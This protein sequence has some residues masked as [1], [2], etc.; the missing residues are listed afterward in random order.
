MERGRRQ[1]DA[2]AVAALPQGRHRDPRRH[3]RQA[4]VPYPVRARPAGRRRQRPA[5]AA[6]GRKRAR[7]HHP[8]ARLHAGRAELPLCQPAA[9]RGGSAAVAAAQFL[10]AGDRRCRVHRR[11][12]DLPA[13]ARQ[14]R[15]QPLG[16]RP[17]PGHAR[18][19]AAGGRRAGR[20]RAQARPRAGARHARGADRRHAQPR[21]PR[22]GAGAARRGLPGRAHG[23]GRP[24]RHPPRP[25][26]HARR[27]GARAAGRLDRRLRSQ[28]HAG[29]VLARCRLGREARAAQSRARLPGRQ[30]RRRDAGAGRAAICAR[31]QHDRPLR[32][33]VGAGQQL[34]PGPRARAG[35]LL[36]A[37]RRRRAGDRQ[38]VLA[39][40]HA[41]RQRRPAAGPAR[42]QAHHRYRARADGASRL[43]PAQPQ[44]RALADLQLLLRQPG[45][46]PCRRRLG[47]PLLGRPGAGAGRHQPA[48]GGAPGAGDG[49]LAEVRTGA[50]RPHARRAGTRRR[51][52]HAVARRARDRR[53]GAGRLSGGNDT[54]S[55]ANAP[56]ARP[57]GAGHVELRPSKEN[58]P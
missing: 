33:A 48:G 23:R 27:P 39:A 47:L 32:R 20:A 14:R 5:A 30:R 56:Y 42:R 57:G 53:Q 41:A 28:C 36:P 9:R 4:A 37:L 22:A 19:A 40:G 51:L 24:R 31:R 46:V 16:S 58:Q 45:A 10:R 43:Q 6:R 26:V 1:P 15:L 18:A 3:A 29:P 17:A 25:P 7:R 35:R 50:A 44:P 49:P 54:S 12:A 55:P 34:R 2:D 38:V 21:L 8:R 13:V 11:A 52:H